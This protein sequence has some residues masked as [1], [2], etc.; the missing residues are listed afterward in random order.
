M[1]EEADEPDQPMPDPAE[2]PEWRLS[3]SLK[4]VFSGLYEGMGF[5]GLM[6]NAGA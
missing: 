3:G 2:V 4:G 1:P 5:K 6:Y